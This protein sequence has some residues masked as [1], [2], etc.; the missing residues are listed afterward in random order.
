MKKITN[1]SKSFYPSILKEH[2]INLTSKSRYQANIIFKNLDNLAI[3]IKDYR[4]NMYTLNHMFKTIFLV[5]PKLNFKTSEIKVLISKSNYQCYLV[6]FS[7]I[8]RGTRWVVPV[9]VC[10]ST[11]HF[12]YGHFEE[13]LFPKLKMKKLILTYRNEE[14]LADIYFRIVKNIN[15]SCELLNDAYKLKQRISNKKI[16]RKNV[17]NLFKDNHDIYN[18]DKITSKLKSISN[19][20]DLKAKWNKFKDEENIKVEYTDVLKYLEKLS[21]YLSEVEV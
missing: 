6:S 15:L 14:L 18:K 16:F 13:V 19:N 20:Q 2:F 7:A 21:S 5:N 11:K 12:P 1:S 9:T 10:R 17:M 3:C 8:Y 4:I